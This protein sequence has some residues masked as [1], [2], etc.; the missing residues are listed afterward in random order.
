MPEAIARI[1]IFLPRNAFRNYLL[2]SDSVNREKIGS[3]NG[4]EEENRR[5]MQLHLS[6]VISSCV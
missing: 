6:E 1:E 5:N 4:L 3:S 2:H